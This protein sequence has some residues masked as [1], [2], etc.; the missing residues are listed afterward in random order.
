MVRKTDAERVR[1]ARQ[2][3]IPLDAPALEGLGATERAATVSVLAQLLLEASGLVNE[4][5]SNEDD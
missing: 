4:E 2:L 5:V 1:R 3:V